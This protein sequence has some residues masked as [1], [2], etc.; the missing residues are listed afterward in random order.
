MARGSSRN[1]RRLQ[2][3]VCGKLTEPVTD[4]ESARQVVG[5]MGIWSALGVPIMIG[6]AATHGNDADRGTVLR[7]DR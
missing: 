2:A 7:D 5:Q 1:L 4:P 6:P 3:T